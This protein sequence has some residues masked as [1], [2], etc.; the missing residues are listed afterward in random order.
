[1][2]TSGPGAVGGFGEESD[3]ADVHGGIAGSLD[4]KELYA[5]EM[6]NLAVVGGGS[7][8][9]LDAHLREVLLGKDAGGEVGV[10]G[11][12]GDVSGAE[13]SSEDGG[14]GSH[15]GGK[16]ERGGSIAFTGFHLGDGLFEMGPRGVVR[17]RVGVGDGGGVTRSVI[18]SGEDGAGME[19]LSGFGTS[20][21][22]AWMILVASRMSRLVWLPGK[23]AA[24]Q[25]GLSSVVALVGWMR[26][27][28]GLFLF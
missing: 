24:S 17:A 9:K 4:P 15:A 28:S 20:E 2:A 5:F 3:V 25:R 16:D 26:V 1:M 8:T 21:R 10:V 18:G 6:L 13:D 27:M 19:G 11:E 7:E 14:T 12:D 22:G 23:S